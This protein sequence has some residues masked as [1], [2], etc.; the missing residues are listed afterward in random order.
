MKISVS[1]L[2]FAGFRYKELQALPAHIGLELF[3]EFGTEYY[4][5]KILQELFVDQNRRQLSFHGPC[6]SVNLADP[7]DTHYLA[8]YESFFR[9]AA[10]W[11]PDFIVL[12]T[13]EA[14]AGE[15]TLLR[16]LVQKRL[17]QLFDLASI[18]DI[19]L[20]IENVGLIAKENLLYNHRQY[21]DLLQKFPQA[22]ALIDTG[23]AHANAWNLPEFIQELGPR[24]LGVHLH[25]N[26]GQQDEHLPIGEGSI[27][28]TPV[29]AALQAY[30]S[31]ASLI[32]EYD[33]VNL[34]T[35]QNSI[36]LL[37]NRFT[38]VANLAPFCNFS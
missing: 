19:R 3:I 37:E 12:H 21:F 38:T 30:A 13:N 35:V 14:L 34:V 22:Y 6:L 10:P 16:E 26:H 4:W 18:Y 17:E 29:F 9:F 2:S 5:D 7:F 8:L 33:H 28:W 11:K 23:H 27:D 1:N 24:L 36:T 15:A 31:Q 32:L 20:V 25:D